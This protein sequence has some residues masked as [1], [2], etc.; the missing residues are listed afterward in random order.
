[1]DAESNHSHSAEQDYK[2]SW[3]KRSVSA[4]VWF[5]QLKAC[6]LLTLLLEGCVTL[7]PQRPLL[8]RVR[9]GELFRL[10]PPESARCKPATAKT[11]MQRPPGPATEAWLPGPHRRR[12]HRDPRA[13]RRGRLALRAPAPSGGAGL[14]PGR[15]HPGRLAPLGPARRHLSA[16]GTK[17][18][19]SGCPG[20][21]QLS[22]AARD[23][24]ARPISTDPRG[25]RAARQGHSSGGGG[26]QKALPPRSCACRC[27][28]P[29]DAGEP[30]SP[31]G[32][33]GQARR[34][35]SHLP[36][37]RAPRRPGPVQAAGSRRVPLIVPRTSPGKQEAASAW[38]A[39]R[40]LGG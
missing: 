16:S 10:S 32:R 3:H 19:G 15:A 26:G 31:A 36:A 4:A 29:C 21:P 23:T 2:T 25:T 14:P 7:K 37:A 30:P 40:A 27:A 8:H 24:A 35:R 20:P 33:I 5:P 1:M 38:G 9:T 17:R 28:D 22:P 13:H 39:P 34:R 11:L 6:C 12:P 18:G